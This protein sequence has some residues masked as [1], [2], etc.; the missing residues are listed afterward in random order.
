MAGQGSFHIVSTTW[1]F[2]RDKWLS[3]SLQDDTGELW[4]LLRVYAWKR[5]IFMCGVIIETV[6]VDQLLQ[7]KL[8]DPEHLGADIPD[9]DAVM[10]LMLGNLISLAVKVKLIEPVAEQ[11][12]VRDL[13]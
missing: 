3:E 12:Q 7:I 2:I 11:L 6:L 1:E 9:K 4:K 8:R 10:G 5:D 13:S